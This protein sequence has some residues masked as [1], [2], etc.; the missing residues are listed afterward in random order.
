MEVVDSSTARRRGASNPGTLLQDGDST[1]DESKG[2]KRDKMA[3][4]NEWPASGIGMEGRIP[5]TRKEFLANGGNGTNSNTKGANKWDK[6]IK[7][8]S[9]VTWVSFF[10]KFH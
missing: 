5:E 7:E 6:L 2:E 4:N 9:K 1:E 8:P 10:R 3:L